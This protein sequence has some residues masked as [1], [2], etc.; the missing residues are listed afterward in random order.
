MQQH[1]CWCRVFCFEIWGNNRSSRTID[2]AKF[3]MMHEV[4]S[5]LVIMSSI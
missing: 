1:I 2:D 3:I 4:S 5:H